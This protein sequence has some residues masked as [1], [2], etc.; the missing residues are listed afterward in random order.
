MRGGHSRARRRVGARKRSEHADR[1]GCS[2]SVAA[3]PAPP[4]EYCSSGDPGLQRRMETPLATTSAAGRTQKTTPHDLTDPTDSA[5]W[6]NVTC[7]VTI[8][9]THRSA[10]WRRTRTRWSNVG[11]QGIHTSPPKLGGGRE[12]RRSTRFAHPCRVSWA[13]QSTS[14]DVP[15]A[16]APHPGPCEAVYP[17]RLVPY[18]N[19]DRHS[20][21]TWN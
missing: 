11:A 20:V 1:E 5:T 3:I 18:A 6:T 2:S 7:V 15:A 9:L 17:R 16:V 13:R 21:P 8:G 4:D 12:G 10:R 14:H 19:P